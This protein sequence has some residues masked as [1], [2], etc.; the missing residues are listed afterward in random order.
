MGS[1]WF[2]YV[3]GAGLELLTNLYV[4][5]KQKTNLRSYRWNI[6]QEVPSSCGQIDTWQPYN[7]TNTGGDQCSTTDPAKCAVGD[8]SGR[9]GTVSVGEEYNSERTL[10]RDTTFVKS[11][12]VDITSRF[13][14]VNTDENNIVG[15]SRIV[16][17]NQ[18]QSVV[19]F[20][21]DGVAGTIEFSQASPYDQTQVVVD[22]N[23]LQNKA[24]G[25]HIH[26]HPVPYKALEDQKTCDAASVGGHFNPHGITSNPDPKTASLDMYEVGDLSGKFGTMADA[27]S[28][29]GT[30]TDSNLPMFGPNSIVGKSVVIHLADGGA[31]WVCGNIVEKKAV[32]TAVATFKY[33]VSGYVLMRQIPDE[34]FAETS[35]FVSLDYTDGSEH[36]EFVVSKWEIQDLPVGYDSDA[37]E[38]SSRCLSTGAIYD[39]GTRAAGSEVIC[40]TANHWGCPVGD[41]TRKLSN[42]VNTTG[43]KAAPKKF[44]FVDTNLPLSGPRSVV[45]RSVVIYGS[46]SRSSIRIACATIQPVKAREAKADQ[47]SSDVTGFIEFSQA[48]GVIHQLTD[49]RIGLEHLN[50]TAKSYH[51]HRFPVPKEGTAASPCSGKSVSGHF[52]PFNVEF[53][54]SPPPNTG[55]NDQY[56]VG[57]LSGKFGLIVDKD[58]YE[59][60]LLDANLNLF[61]LNSI[62]G[63]SIV[64]HK[65]DAT[66]SRWVCASI[67]EPVTSIADGTYIQASATFSESETT[68]TGYI[69]MVRNIASPRLSVRSREGMEV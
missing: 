2:R 6:L 64:I 26:Q 65:N 9:L 46:G 67:T 39:P 37:E 16:P 60:Q 21:N 3:D 8:L 30:Y 58:T 55:S 50:K 5:N 29:S 11:S 35:V 59:K 24:G 18:R 63:R 41:L 52:N 49:I 69:R 68:L 34:E 62:V 1:I 40:S 61:G 13:I 28:L 10:F 15:C 53:K 43:W 42:G 51:V 12:E 4:K 44:T 7:P 19:T 36:K 32:V 23:K 56:E 25:Y 57:D 48:S 38:E 33:P 47:W 54:N 22:V 20:S 17:V 31:R 66:T 14:I 45:G 27:A